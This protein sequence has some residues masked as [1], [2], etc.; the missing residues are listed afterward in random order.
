VQDL[1]LA[2][3]LILAGRV[4]PP[5]ALP[6]E[7]MFAEHDLPVQGEPCSSLLCLR[8]GLAYAPNLANEPRGFVQIGMSS[9]IKPA[10]FRRKPLDLMLTI[11][12]S[13]SMGIEYQTGESSYQS[14]I[15]VAKDLAKRIVSNLLP[16]DRVGIVTFGEQAKLVHPMT[17]VNDTAT[18]LAIIDGLQ[19][20]GSTNI[21]DG[22]RTSF[23]NFAAADPELKRLRRVALF[24]DANPN[25]A[26]TAPSA[27]MSQAKAA[28]Q[29]GTGLT[30]FAFG[31]GIRSDVVNAIAGLRGGNAYSL[32][33]MVDSIK[34]IENDWPW[35][36]SPIAYDL[37]VRLLPASSYQLAKGYGFPIGSQ[38]LAVSTVFLSNRRGAVLV[39]LKPLSS[40]GTTDAQRLQALQ[41]VGFLE[42]E[43]EAGQKQT[44]KIDLKMPAEALVNIN[45]QVATQLG[46]LKATTLAMFAANAQEAARLYA[47]NRPMAVAVLTKALERLQADAVAQNDQALKETIPFGQSL[48]TL[49]KSNAPQGNLYR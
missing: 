17:P 1:G 18:L 42:Y 5:E 32:F 36:T 4:P 30:T 7:G 11:D 41:V 28:A 19:P 14:P 37:K 16:T 8:A 43:D 9:T 47:T 31:V 35:F 39:E 44:Q 29:Q 22:L 15:N 2:R 6:V 25:V 26:S 3:E 20:R 49:M 33:T 27:F 23:S 21:E 38:G 10:E 12:V 45:G 24:T 48:L 46:T 13:G 40:A 34:T